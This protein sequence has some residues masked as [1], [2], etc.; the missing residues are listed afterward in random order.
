MEMLRG[1]E[2]SLGLD[3]RWEIVGDTQFDAVFYR[4]FRECLDRSPVR[5]RIVMRGA[6]PEPEGGSRL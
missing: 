5:D 6:L 4:E 1:L 2:T 3:W